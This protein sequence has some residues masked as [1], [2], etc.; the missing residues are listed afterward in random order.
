[1]TDEPYKL[2]FLGE[3]EEAMKIA[4]LLTHWSEPEVRAA[5]T[6]EALRLVDENDAACEVAR[7]AHTIKAGASR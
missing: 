4:L 3:R 7:A 5:I 1:M 2:R 6:A